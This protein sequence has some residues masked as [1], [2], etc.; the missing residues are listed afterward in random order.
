M[1]EHEK[2]VTVEGT[3]SN[4]SVSKFLDNQ[5]PLLVSFREKCPG[6]FKHSKSV[7]AMIEGVALNLGLDEEV[8]KLAAIYHDVGKMFN[9]KYFTENQLEDENIHKDLD[10]RM[11]Y[12]IITRHVSDS[13]VILINEDGFPRKV[14]DIIS[15]HH[16]Q[17]VLRYFFNLAKG[18]G[19]VE[20]T[21]RYKT[22]KPTHLESAILMICDAVEATSRAKIQA[23]CFNPADV[24]ETTINTLIDDGQLDEVTLKLGNL[25]RIKVALGK[26]LEGTYQKRVDYSAVDVDSTSIAAQTTASGKG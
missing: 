12:E 23:G 10:P 9:P 20:D 3:P 6:T 8:L 22:T 19:E 5:Y 16:G 17:T 13:V 21:Y 14:I 18:K 25:K 11:S 7:A 2:S 4:G 26:E 15:Q 24:I 1:D